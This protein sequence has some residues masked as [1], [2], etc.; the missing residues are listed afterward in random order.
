MRRAPSTECRGRAHWVP[1]VS[2]RDRADRGVDAEVRL[3]G[4]ALG[5]EDVE[6]VRDALDE[7]EGVEVDRTAGHA[8]DAA[9]VDDEVAVDED[10]HVVVAL[11]GEGLAAVVDE[12]GVDLGREVV[13]VLGEGGKRLGIRHNCSKIPKS[14]Q[15]RSKF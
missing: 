7:A 6:V 3:G 15:N 14:I 12:L 1:R 8:V 9:E 11:E 5:V 10:P 13:D 4:V 2:L